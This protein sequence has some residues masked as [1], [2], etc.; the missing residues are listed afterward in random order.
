M[1]YQLIINDIFDYC[2]ALLI[3]LARLCGM[4]YEE[5]NVWFFIVVEP[6][7]FVGVCL[8]AVYQRRQNIYLRKRSGPDEEQNNNPCGSCTGYLLSTRDSR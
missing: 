1:N 7:V 4:T 8:Y 2:V 3:H 6:V 5:I